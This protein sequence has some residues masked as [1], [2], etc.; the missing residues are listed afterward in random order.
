MHQSS[1][2]KDRK[3][4]SGDR[5]GRRRLHRL[6][7]LS[8]GS[9]SSSTTCVHLPFSS[10]R[11]RL[12]LLRSSPDWFDSF[13]IVALFSLGWYEAA[14][15]LGFDTWKTKFWNPNHYHARLGVYCTFFAVF[16]PFEADV[17]PSLPPPPLPPQTTLS[18][19]FAA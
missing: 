16:S 11:T 13:K 9:P 15:D 17:G 18:L 3:Y 5:S 10:S 6:S 8:F 2:W 7:R 1:R 12:D 4:I 19:S 14:A